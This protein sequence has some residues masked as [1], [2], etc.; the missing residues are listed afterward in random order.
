VPPDPFADLPN[1][2]ESLPIGARPASGQAIQKCAASITRAG[3]A[4]VT[5]G[6][7]IIQK[8]LTDAFTCLHT[9]L[10]D[11]GCLATAQAKCATQL[12]KLK[13]PKLEDAILKGCG[14]LPFDALARSDGLNLE[15]LDPKCGEL[16]GGPVLTPLHSLNDYVACVRQLH[17]CG[18][19]DL[20]RFSVPRGSALLPDDALQ[21]ALRGDRCPSPPSRS[22]LASAVSPRASTLLSGILRFISS[23]RRAG[24]SAGT[25]HPGVA[26][27]S[28]GTGRPIS[29]VSGGLF[30][31][32]GGSNQLFVRYRRGITRT[33][34][35]TQLAAAA[36]QASLLI[37]VQRTDNSDVP[38]YFELPLP[39]DPPTGQTSSDCPSLDECEV[40]VDLA[41]PADL[42]GCT[43]NLLVAATEGGTVSD[44]RGIEQI[45]VTSDVIPT[46]DVVFTIS[47]TPGVQAFRLSARYPRAKGD[48]AG[49]SD[50]AA[51]EL[52]GGTA[53]VFVANDKN[54]GTLVLA[55][56]TAPALAF[57]LEVRC[58]FNQVEGTL[59]K[60]KKGDITVAVDE[61][62]VGGAPANVSA[63]KVRVVLP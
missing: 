38:D 24:G 55:A 37:K 44:Y 56:G 19:L 51:C 9:K 52:A 16:R 48:F 5:G 47:G 1:F 63:L 33:R 14:A 57:P 8:C 45:P 36:G 62:T 2:N 3:D 13:K 35:A 61:V 42:R 11:G 41:F 32:R 46:K 6:L 17:Q 34:T 21:V 39:A 53:T 25:Y 4:F 50:Q 49:G 26:P 31:P 54:D 29:G 15:A 18:L 7:A 23:L 27:A 12:E 58:T 10:D 60:L 20:V 59:S 28:G 30:A 43:F 40:A 22:T